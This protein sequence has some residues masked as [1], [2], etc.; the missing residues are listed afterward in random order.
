MSAT[1]KSSGSN[2]V[3]AMHWFRKGLRLHDNPGLLHSIKLVNSSSQVGQIYPVYIVDP[4]SYQLLKCSVN[5]AKFL[6]ECVSDLDTSLKECGSRLYVATGDP[7]DV[8]PTLWQ[9]WNVTHMTHEADE[10]GEPYALQR[11]TEVQKI[12]KK[13]GVQVMSFE[14]E[15]L[16][17]LGNA[18]GGYVANVGGSAAADVPKTM[19][20]FQALL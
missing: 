19:A 13:E 17:P 3:V 7:V 5:R 16:R 11:D 8:L 14:S 9:E 10:T 18:T 6:L 12:A 20:S 2:A 15:T 1:T 4:N